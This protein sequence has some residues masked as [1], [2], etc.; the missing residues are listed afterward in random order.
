VRILLI[1][2]FGCAA[3]STEPAV[4]NAVPDRTPP[5]TSLV[6]RWRVIGCETSPMDP[7]DC[8]RGQIVFTTDRVTIDVPTAE[9]ISHAY[10]LV[11]SSTR[12]IVLNV[13]GE[14]SDITLDA[15]G[16]AHW[17]ALG[18]DGRVGRLSFVRAPASPSE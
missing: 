17:R 6:G 14:D 3:P 4:K 13:D 1:A 9:H 11:S 10:K 18:L 16:E 2:W 8:A 12:H 15:N 5:P 7:A